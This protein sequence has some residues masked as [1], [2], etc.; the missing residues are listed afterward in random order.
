MAH[1]G[2]SIVVLGF[3]LMIGMVGFVYTED[4]PVLDAFLNSSMLLGGMGPIKTVGLS[5]GGKLFSG[6]YALYTGLVLIAVMSIMIAPVV[7]RIMHRMHW[8]DTEADAADNEPGS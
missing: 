1:S 2:I 3:S 6:I 5:D 8:G 7:H 4:M